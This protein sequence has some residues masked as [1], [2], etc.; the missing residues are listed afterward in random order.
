MFASMVST[1]IVGDICKVNNISFLADRMHDWCCHF[2][3]S[4]LDNLEHSE[5][6]NQLISTIFNI[7]VAS[8]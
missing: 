3:Y 2:D 8:T 1:V 5:T 7:A 6:C 4:Q